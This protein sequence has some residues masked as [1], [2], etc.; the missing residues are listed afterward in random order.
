MT[1]RTLLSRRA[2]RAALAAA[3]LIAAL[4]VAGAASGATP[5]GVVGCDGKAHVKPAVVVL[6]CGDGNLGIRKVTWIGWGG[7]T[8]VGIGT[9]FYND[10]TPYCAAGKFHSF[11]AVV[12]ATGTQSCHGGTAYRTLTGA[13]VGLAP[14]SLRKPADATY[15]LICH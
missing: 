3:G 1:F 5:T 10:C 7:A 8:T 6:A 15:P 11:Q 13:V 14:L 4:A 9:G 12:V 2:A